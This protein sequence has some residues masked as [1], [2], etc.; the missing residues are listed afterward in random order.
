MTKNNGKLVFE[1]LG[2]QYKPLETKMLGSEAISQD[3]QNW[4]RGLSYSKK[5]VVLDKYAQVIGL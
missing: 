2:F 4:Y 1:M 3:F 5:M